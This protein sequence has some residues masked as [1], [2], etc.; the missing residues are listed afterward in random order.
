[1]KQAYCLDIVGNR[2]DIG[3]LNL[4]LK[5]TETIAYPQEDPLQPTLPYFTGEILQTIGSDDSERRFL[6]YIPKNFPISGAGL[7]LYPDSGVSCEAFLADGE[8]KQI[9]EEHNVALIVLEAA[10]DGWSHQDIQREITYSEQVFKQTISRIRFSLNEATYYIMGFG[11]GAYPATAYALLNSAL[12]SCLIADGDYSLDGRLLEQLETIRS[13]RDETKSKLD[14]ALPAWL[15]N[16]A[17]DEGGAVAERL[18]YACRAIDRGLR[19]CCADVFQQDLA[20]WQNTLDGLPMTEVW[21]T[22]A[23]EAAALENSF[24]HRQM[25]AFALRFKRWLGIGNGDLRP[26][27]TAREM[28]L[29]RFE[30]EIDGRIREWYVYEPTAYR[31]NPSKKI[32]AVLAIHG[33]S[34]TGKLFAENSEWHMVGERRGFFVLYVSAYPSNMHSGG[35]TVPLPTWNSVGMEAETDDMHYISTVISHFKAHYPVD[36]ERIYVSGHSNGSL[37]TQRLM[38]EKPLEF[39]AFAPQGA[40]Y[41]L[42][43]E[44]ETCDIQKDGVIRPV[45]LMMGHEDIGDGDSL[46]NGSSNNRFIDMMCCV[47]GL[48]RTRAQKLENGRYRT[49]TFV[50]EKRVPLLRFTGVQDLPHAFTPEMAQM[51]WDLFFCHFR[52]K[53]DGTVGYTD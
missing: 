30:A 29:R 25:V 40:Q 21:F 12:F 10:L 13:D 4:F 36:D 23:R 26:A 47:N 33:Y 3:D 6:I 20:R 46:A 37:M 15:V 11:A 49:L 53:A 17:S 35:R 41:H 43:L 48:D 5:N 24:L 32:P 8:W 31:M 18:R 16:R 14:V 52:R 44:D 9:A 42:F 45:W 34:C 51:F 38:R 22:G 28:G 7:F 50:D 2:Y 27:R 39:A 19:V 1:M